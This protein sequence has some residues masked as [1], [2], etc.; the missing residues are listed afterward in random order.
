[1]TRS[2]GHLTRM[3]GPSTSS[4]GAARER[5]AQG[6]GQVSTSSTSEEPA[7]ASVAV[8]GRVR[9]G[10]DS[11]YGDL[12]G[13]PVDETAEACRGPG[14]DD[15]A[16]KE[17]PD[18]RD[19]F[20]QFGD[21]VYQVFRVAVSTRLAIDEGLDVEVVDVQLSFDH[22]AERAERVVPLRPRPLPIS[23][24]LVTRRHVVGDRV[25]ED[26]VGIVGGLHALGDPPDDDREFAFVDDATLD[27][28]NLD[29]LPRA[30]HRRVRLEEDQG[31]G[32]SVDRHL[33]LVLGIVEAHAD[34]FGPRDD[35]C[36]QL[37]VGNRDALTGR[38]V[39]AEHRVTGK[40]DEVVPVNDSVPGI[41]TIN[42]KARDFHRS[43]LPACVQPLSQSGCH[44][45]RYPSR[46]V[47]QPCLS[48]RRP[49]WMSVSSWRRDMVSSPA[50]ASAD[51]ISK[52]SALTTAI[53]VTTAAVPQA[54]IS[55]MS[56]D[57]TP[58]R[59]SSMLTRRRS[60]VRPR[61]SASCRMLSRVI[62]SRMLSESG[63]TSVP[64][65]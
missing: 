63:V 8:A 42:C 5:A 61:S 18:I 38:L 2:F 45:K 40:H 56:P 10:A 29:G 27:I 48:G 39:P 32:G 62:P 11:V 30:D 20:D 33:R 7:R 59:H 51:P 21:L 53:G 22:R 54:N 25:A 46:R 17:R 9:K 26:V 36:Q 41:N 65:L 35:G 43:S 1:M 50:A 16:G 49:Y 3:G 24:H 13:L 47:S 64:S 55:T 58:S 52:S 19:V 28:R 37:G 44:R 12:D 60:T 4:G 6:R 23:K 31:C 34:H 15:V 57:A 14:E